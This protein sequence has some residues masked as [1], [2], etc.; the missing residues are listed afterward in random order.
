MILFE[1]EVE[2][3]VNFKMIDPGYSVIVRDKRNQVEYPQKELRFGYSAQFVCCF[4][5]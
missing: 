1:R 3:T 2:S 5:R 4:L